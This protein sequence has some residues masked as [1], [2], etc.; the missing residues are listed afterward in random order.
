MMHWH[1]DGEKGREVW[2]GAGLKREV[3]DDRAQGFLIF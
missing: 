3:F 2:G 1:Y